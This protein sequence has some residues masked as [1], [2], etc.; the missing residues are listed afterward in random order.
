MAGVHQIGPQLG[1]HQ[2]ADAG[3]EMSQKTRDRPGE[4]VGQVSALHPGGEVAI[5]LCGGSAAGRGHVGEEHPVV[6]IGVEQ[7]VDERTGR[8]YYKIYYDEET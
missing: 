1:F 7:G 5:Q 2:D 3:V 8:K 6:G 4:V